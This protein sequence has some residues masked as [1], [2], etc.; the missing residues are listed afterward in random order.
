M[1]NILK[2]LTT[3]IMLLIFF[4][5]VLITSYFIISG[6]Y[7]QVE[8]LEH[9]EGEKLKY[10]VTSIATSLDGD[11]HE[12]MM[13]DNPTSS[14]IKSVKE[15]SSYWMIHQILNKNYNANHLNNVLYTL[16]L[17]QSKFN[18]Y[19]GVRSDTFIDFRNRYLLFPKLL[20][21]NYQTGGV[22][23]RYKTEN[24]EYI[25]AFYP[26]KNSKNKV[27]ALL[28]A[29]IEFTSFI[30][31]VYQQ[32]FKQAIY[33]LIIILIIA[34]ILIKFSL[35]ILTKEKLTKERLLV[36]SK[37]IEKKNKEIFDSINYA[38]Q[39]QE[40]HLPSLKHIEDHLP[41]TFILYKPKD[42]VSGDFY[43]FEH[44]NDISLIAV[45]DCTGHGIP[46]ALMS[47]I[48][49]SKLD[50]IVSVIDDLSPDNV[51]TELDKN[52]TQTLSDNNYSTKIYDGM[53]I[54]LCAIDKEQMTLDFSSAFRPLIIINN[55]ELKEIKGERFPIGGGT[56]YGDKKFKSHRINLKKGDNIYLFSDGYVDQ[57]GGESRKRFKSKKFR[58]L[59]ISISHLRPGQQKKALDKAILDWQGK[60]PQI[61]D[62]LIIGISF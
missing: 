47:M 60:T 28:E 56:L 39:I 61:D 15:D 48:G 27:V 1:K 20:L 22:I 17:D 2:N 45:A 38:L 59:L 25:S 30:N 32:Y 52:I 51:L 42:I 44:I 4:S 26:I 34:L 3:R 16:V 9:E 54:V 10:L 49:H 14:S 62:I 35:K 6:Y 57:L 43:W 13:L 23:P 50:S 29:D 53:D 40:A 36:K 24:G 33:S 8:L 7:K 31:Q 46:G 5:I 18:F 21:D 58:E 19:Y 55:K 11:V 41:N 12:K 37:I